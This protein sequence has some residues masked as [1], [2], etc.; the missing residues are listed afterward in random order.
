M[1]ASGDLMEAARAKLKR[2]LRR[3]GR[4]NG[5]DYG[6]MVRE[7]LQNFFYS[8][9]QSRPVILSNIVRV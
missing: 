4:Q 9:T 2:D 7:T 5:H 6:Q 8:K 3:N 1:D